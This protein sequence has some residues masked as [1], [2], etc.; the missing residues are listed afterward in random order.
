MVTEQWNSLKCPCLWGWRRTP[1]FPLDLM[2]GALLTGVFTNASVNFHTRVPL[3]PC[4]MSRDRKRS[5]T[6]KWF[7]PSMRRA[8]GC[9]IENYQGISNK[10]KRLQHQGSSAI[11]IGDPI[12][13][14]TYQMIIR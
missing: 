13:M 10:W 8:H 3:S 4:A 12:E 6:R 7:V 11:R 5:T 1:A 9:S 2:V 14:M